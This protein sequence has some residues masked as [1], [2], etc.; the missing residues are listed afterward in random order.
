MVLQ[1]LVEMVKNG[2]EACFEKSY[3]MALEAEANRRAKQDPEL[4]EVTEEEIAWLTAR[5]PGCEIMFPEHDD[6]TSIQGVDLDVFYIVIDKQIHRISLAK[7]PTRIQP[8]R[9]FLNGEKLLMVQ[10]ERST[11]NILFL[12]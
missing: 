5:Y 8:V 12:H 10:G 7:A 2:V 4:G 11:I 1:F 6:Y 9:G 3:E